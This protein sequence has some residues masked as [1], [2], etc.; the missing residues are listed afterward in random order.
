[1][2]DKAFFS[3]GSVA[4]I[5]A[6]REPQKLGYSV[7]KNILQY[8]FQGKV[9]PVNPVASQILELPCYPKVTEIPHE[10]ELAVVVVPP[11]AVPQVISDCGQKGVRGVVVITAGFRE[12]GPEGLKLENEMLTLARKYSIK[13]L[14][15]NCLGFIDTESSL[16]VTFATGM[17]A[18]GNIAFMSQSGALCQAVL[19]WSRD[20]GIGFSKFI[21]LGNKADISETDIMEVLEGDKATKVIIAYVEGIAQGDR[22]RQVAAAVT[23]VKP[24]ILVKAGGTAAG[25]KAASSHTG[26]LAGF[27]AAYDA[28]FKQTGVLKAT[29]IEN[30]FDLAL[31]FAHQPIL[32]GD[33]LAIVTNGGGPGIMASDACERAGLRIASFTK[34]TIDLLRSKLPPTANLYNPVDVIGDAGPDRYESALQTVIS[35]PNV[36]GALVLLIPAALTNVEETAAVILEAAAESPKP[37]FTSF[38]GGSA[39]TEGVKSLSQKGVPNYPFPERAVNGFAAMSRYRQWLERKLE[40]PELFEVDGQAA[41]VILNEAKQ[42]GRSLL[43][44]ME[45]RRVIETYGLPLSKFLLAHSA[46]E[47]V[48]NAEEIGY[49]VVTKIVSPDILHKTDIGG[50]RVGLE[51]PEAVRSAYTEVVESARRLMPQAQVLGVDI[52]TMV[53]GKEVILGVSRDPQFGPLLMFG[54]GGV[55]VEVLKDVSFRV[56]PITRQDAMDMIHEIRSYPLLA[57]VR[58]EKTADIKA[59]VECLLRL[60][61]LVTDFPQIMELDINPLM[62]GEVGEGAIAVDCRMRISI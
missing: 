54:F 6:A 10:V 25:A 38:M 2:L 28:V 46:D 59:I 17:P 42:L 3:P 36:D 50:V 12:T 40:A 47:A 57:G 20:R 14:G 13:L 37:I 49:P 15:P 44:D 5:G 55:Y 4:V 19:D 29:S 23:R 51:N 33:R 1:M 61:Q 41:Q 7:L 43:S 62:V 39:V 31:A 56:A 16:N 26:T 11:V 52:Q 8:E 21:S 58:G 60:S 32:Q 9:Y 27:D 48:N 53:K 30:L 35:D 18:K 24:L 22:F 45:A 34:E